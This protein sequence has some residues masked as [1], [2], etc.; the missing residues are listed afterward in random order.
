[1]AT[2]APTARWRVVADAHVRRTRDRPTGSRAPERPRRWAPVLTIVG[3]EIGDGSVVG[4]VGI[5]HRSAPPTDGDEWPGCGPGRWLRAGLLSGETTIAPACYGP[6]GPMSG[7]STADADHRE[8]GL[9]PIAF[10][11]WRW[12]A[13]SRKPAERYSA[14]DAAFERREKTSASRRPAARMSRRPW[15]MTT[16]P[17]PRR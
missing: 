16:R 17:R 3:R 8:P 5:G 11:Y 4:P 12:S 15:R 13:S 7:G 1:M 9:R 2:V 14:S 6:S 10:V